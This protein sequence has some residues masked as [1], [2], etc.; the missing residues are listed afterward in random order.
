MMT[1]YERVMAALGGQQPDRVPLLEFVIDPRIVKAICPNLNTQTEF[2]ETMDF[3]AVCCSADYRR[4][5][6]YPD[7]TYLDEWGVLYKPGPELQDHPIKGPI[8]SEADLREYRCPSPDV[9]WRLGVLPDLVKRFKFKKAIV[10]RHRAAFMW[11]AFLNGMDN[12]LMNFLTAPTF[13]HQLLDRV[14]EVNI[15]IARMA[16]RVGADVIVLGDDYAGTQ[17]PFF[18]PAVFKE[19]ILPPLQKMVDVIHEEGAK[20][21]KHSDGNLWLIL[22]PIINT[23]I[24]GINPIE[25]IAG[26]DIGEVKQ[27]YREKACLV[28]NID[29]SHLLPYGTESE[30]DAAVKECIRKASFGGGHMICSSNSIHSSV[31]PRNY[32]AMI[33]AAKRYGVYPLSAAELS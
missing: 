8:S 3:D 5:R 1:S 15:K 29:V 9:P 31:N 7:G 4:A 20:V 16:I 18:S 13:A 25:P 19:F 11:S 33:N 32:L 14:L 12:L 6:E 30:V 2:E 27:K 23:G 17:G 26:M 28:G 24:D 10:Y 21:I 22:D